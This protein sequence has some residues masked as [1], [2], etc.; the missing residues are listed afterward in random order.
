MAIGTDASPFLLFWN[1]NIQ[2]NP[3]YNVSYTTTNRHSAAITGLK[4]TPDNQLISISK[5]KF[6]RSWNYSDKV[7]SIWRTNTFD[8]EYSVGQLNRSLLVIGSISGLIRQCDVNTGACQP[9][10]Y[11]HSSSINAFEILVN[12]DLVS[13]SQFGY[14]KVWT[15][16]NYSWAKYTDNIGSPVKSLKLLLNG[17]L[18][19]G[20]ASGKILIYNISA[21][22]KV[23]EFIA[24]S[25]GQVNA[26]EVLENGDLASGSSDN[27]IKIWDRDNFDLI[28]HLN[29]H[30]SSVN[31]LRLLS[32]CLLASGSDDHMVKVWDLSAMRKV[33]QVDVGQPVKVIELLSHNAFLNLL[34]SSNSGKTETESWVI[35]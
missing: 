2:K 22:I 25:S 10:V 9:P 24:H 1:P 29:H 20:L 27:T 18:A 21:Q 4:Y 3:I 32:D 31:T 33:N 6:V 7:T 26:L 14:I 13:G 30:T 8:E 34:P 23:K 12:G 5:D 11:I 28:G 17:N 15:P 19:C 16:G 35:I